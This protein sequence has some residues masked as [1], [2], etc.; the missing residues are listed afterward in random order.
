[1]LKGLIS[2]KTTIPARAVPDFELGAGIQEK[3]VQPIFMIIYFS[4]E[5]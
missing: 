4:L 3:L 2:I 5:Y 1:L